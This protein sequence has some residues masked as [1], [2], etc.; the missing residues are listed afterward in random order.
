M[1]ED[2]IREAMER[3]DFDNLPGKGKPLNLVDDP[4][5]D[6]L[7]SI[8]NRILRDNGLSHPLI[9][10]RKAM[11]ADA[12]QCRT[13]LARARRE[14]EIT[15]SES[16]W[17]RAIEDFRVRVKEINRQVRTFNLKSPSPALHGLALDADQEIARVCGRRNHTND[18]ASK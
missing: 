2:I 9:E 7:M 14:F 1:V 4:L 12:E 16:A 13:D 3:G 8:V 5:L 6:P 10:A 17:G 11:A 18:P 15:Q